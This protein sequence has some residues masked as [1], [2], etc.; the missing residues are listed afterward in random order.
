MNKFKLYVAV[1]TLA[2]INTGAIAAN[3]ASAGNGDVA[4]MISGV[5]DNITVRGKVTAQDGTPLPGVS[6]KLKGTTVSTL[7]DT[8]GAFMI[9]A[10][11]DGTLVFSFLGYITKEVAVDGNGSMGV[12]VLE[13]GDDSANKIIHTMFRD[14]KAG[15][16]LGGVASV[17]YVELSEKNHGF[18]GDSYLANLGGGW[19]FGYGL[20]LVDGLPTQNTLVFTDIESIT[21]LKGAQAVALYG[22]RGANGVTLIT[23]KRGKNQPIQITGRVNS[24]VSVDKPYAKFLNSAEYMMWYNQALI[25]DGLTEKYSED[26]IADY[27]SHSNPYR[28]PDIDYYSSKY[29]KKV[30]NTTNASAVI[31]G[32]NDFATFYT[33]IYYSYSGDRFKFGE[34]ENNNSTTLTIRG[35]VDMKFND[36]ITASVDANVNMHDS[37]SY[38]GDSYWTAARTMRPNRFAPLVPV[39]YIDPEY[40]AGL[41]LM[42][43]NSNI[44]DG[45]YFLSGTKQDANNVFANIYSGGKGKS[46]ERQ[47]QFD[48]K[49]HFNL[50][51]L[52]KGLSF[53][54]QFGT[55]YATAYQTSFTNQYAIYIPTW[56]D[57]GVITNLVKENE[58]KKSGVQNIGGS[59]TQRMF[60]FN[61]HLDYNRTFGDHSWGGMVLVNGY[62]RAVDGQY[63]KTTNANLSFNVNYDF[64]KKYFVDVT[65]A[66]PHSAKLAEGNRNGFS[67]SGSIGW[68]ISNEDFFDK[69][70]LFNN[71]MLSFSAS[72]LCEDIDIANYYMYAG[73][74]SFKDGWYSWL[75]GN[76]TQPTYSVRGENL[77]LDY[78]HRK[79]LSA[80]V[81]FSMLD[82]SLTFDISAYMAKQTGGI[83]MPTLIPSYFKSYYPA[84]NFT[85]YVNYNENLYKGID[86]GINYKK[87][88]G[89]V[90][91]GVGVFGDSRV[92][93]ADKR[94]ESDL[95]EFEEDKDGNQ[96][97]TAYRKGEGKNLDDVWGY[98]TL[99]IFQ[100]QDEVD[101]YTAEVSYSL[102]GG[103]VMPGDIIYKDVNND[104]T[105]DYKDR[106]VLG[107]GGSKFNLG[108]NLTVSYKNFTLFVVGDG[109][110]G[111]LGVKNSEYVWVNG[112]EKYTKEVCDTWTEQNPKAKYPRLTSKAG[113]T[114][115]FQTSDFWTYKNNRFYLDKIQLTYD[116]PSSMFEGNRFIKGCSVYTYATNI[117]MFAK[118]RD[119]IEASNA[120]YGPQSRFFNVG[121]NVNF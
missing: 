26:E 14:Q 67:K 50:S 68:N 1:C 109:F 70:G 6:V 49:L 36:Y 103:D 5:E 64:A 120:Y 8:D 2:A 42:N 63:H 116:F 75:E 7:T 89:D 20:T 45:K 23:T 22:S 10:T 72:D 19:G 88:F 65:F 55:E 114:N 37:K 4:A 35:N 18:V 61:A 100:S 96:V 39:S 34:A 40:E 82:N 105:I 53:H 98:K 113:E 27:A 76:G 43:K 9:E 59:A 51:P 83:I 33:D 57:D 31:D 84:A 86:F 121:V 104:G 58:D 13:K 38:V 87:Q 66:V 29:I 21:Y 69:N 79:E 11:S 99:G 108:M 56:S 91:V 106:V 118:E 90:T 93:K 17:D 92:S 52:T 115:N 102:G 46:T 28:Y 77:D 110:F 44:I 48:T 85:S 30:Y 15:E 47:F 41:E 71:L 62:Q 73:T 16:I 95:P 94:D 12:V 78:L 25:N 3:P 24:G 101:A 117:F 54:T 32:G 74:W 111:G 97:S 112:E 81:K 60:A 107:R 80:N 119:Y